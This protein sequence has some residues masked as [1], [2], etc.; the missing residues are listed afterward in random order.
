MN[1]LVDQ[2][3]DVNVMPLS[4]Y[5]KLTNKRPAETNIRLSLASHSY[6][7]P[8][9]IAKD[10]LDVDG[11]VYLVDFLILDM[12]EDEKRPFIL[13]T[14]FLKMAKAASLGMG[15]KD[16]TSPRKGDEVRPIEEQKLKNKRPALVKVEDVMDDEGEVIGKGLILYQAYGNLYAMTVKDNGVNILK[17]SDE[18][19]FKMGKFRETLVVGALHRG[20][21]QDRVF[22]DLTPEE[23]ERFKADTRAMNILL[24]GLPKDIYTLINHYTDSKDI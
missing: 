6:I 9:G 21:E 13:G 16:K 2:G 8:L 18:C 19:L 4:T 22:A 10:I 11:Y 15:E 24:Q 23:K 12:K 20:P 17:S 3:S 7:Y 1:A 14:P 5:M